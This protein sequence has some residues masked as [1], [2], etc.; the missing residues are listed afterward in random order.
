MRTE[1]GSVGDL[2]REGLPWT[3][4]DFVLVLDLY[5]RRGRNV[6]R[7]DDELKELA[8]LLRR[9]PGSITRRLGNFAGTESAGTRGL[10]AVT[11][12]GLQVWREFQVRP[13]LLHAEAGGARDRL[14]GPRSDRNSPPGP[15]VPV[16]ARGIRDGLADALRAELVGPVEPTEVLKERPSTRYACGILWPEGTVIEADQNEAQPPGDDEED[17]SGFEESVPLVQ[18]LNPSSI[19]LSV[20]LAPGTRVLSVDAQWGEY[21]REVG[22]RDSEEGEEEHESRALWRRAPIAPGP[23]RIPVDKHGSDRKPVSADGR[24]FVEWLVRPLGP[25]IA[26]SVFL[27]N[28]R[29]RP[30]GWLEREQR[31]IFQPVLSVFEEGGAPVIVGRHP[32]LPASGSGEADEVAARLLFRDELE[33]A[34]GHG[35]AAGWEREV[36]HATRAW[37]DTLPSIELPALVPEENVPGL[38]VDMGKLSDE[39]G[40]DGFERLLHPLTDAYANWIDDLQRRIPALPEH[41]REQGESHVAECRESLRRMRDGIE[42]IKTDATSRRAFRLMNMTMLLQR[43]R[44][45]WA[46]EFRRTGIRER[47]TPDLGARWRPFQL[48][49]ILQC[50]RGCVQTEHEDR[51]IA[52]LL[53]FPTGGGKT[54]AYLGLAAFV[55]FSRRLAHR[56]SAHQGAGVCVLMRYTLRLLTVQQF[57]RAATLAC[58]MEVVRARETDLGSEPF[59]VGIWVGGGTTPNTFEESDKALTRLIRGEGGEGSSLMDEG[60]P[61]QLVSC[62]WCGEQMTPRHYR[63]LGVRRRTL[64]GCPRE[65]CEFSFQS[66]PDGI[67]V[68]VVDEEIYRCLPTLIIGTVDKFARLP[69]KGEAQTLFGRVSRHCPRHGYLSPADD[70]PEARH[71]ARAN[72]SAV[73]VSSTDP[74]PPP[75]LIIQD[76]LHLISGP[77]G[78]MVGLYE[79]GID[80]LAARED[81]GSRVPPKVVASTATVRRA[82][83]QV[84]GLFKRSV[85]VFPPPGLE[86]V[87]SFF[88]RRAA[89]G[90]VPGRMYVGVF[91][92]GKSVK[93]AQVRVVALLLAAA[94]QAFEQDPASADPYMTLVGYFNSLRELGGA[95]NLVRDDIRERLRVLAGRGWPQRR[96][97]EPEELTSRRSSR[98]IPRLLDRLAVPH[99]EREGGKQP[100]DVLLS[101]NMISVG[102]DI[103]RLGL[104]VVVGQPKATAEYIQATSRVGRRAPG[105]IVTIYN[106]SRPRDLSHYERFRSYHSTLYRHVEAT[107][108]TPF[109]SRAR[110]RGLHAIYV[111]MCRAADFDLTP[112]QQ[113]VAYSRDRAVAAD[114]LD[115]LSDRAG[116]V[117]GP[118][119]AEAVRKE[120]VA[121]QDVWEQ[122]T[123][124][125]PLRYSWE[126]VE[127]LPPPGVAILLRLA[128]T[129]RSGV[130]ATPGS[131]REIESQAGI[132]LQEDLP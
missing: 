109:S 27:V 108:V 111:G 55:A 30:S 79:A 75:E 28:R 50:L 91:A 42:L 44:S 20:I 45:D 12:L 26:L 49:F 107:S 48:A 105:L 132:Y 113:A 92:P 97:W 25:A 89:L 90:E 84:W 95:V 1:G 52:D 6:P 112:E 64:M 124:G 13:D 116:A 62:P 94:Q 103:L 51:A 82:P 10:K 102:V 126:S 119:V 68:V 47:E 16:G 57:Q 63:A 80:W 93:T 78:S 21:V 36:D 9:S 72:L 106:W 53:W 5:V 71:G 114:A 117:G 2:G 88:A 77:L 131:L 74:L 86:H 99:A 70:H 29:S 61:V 54:E 58:A 100:V 67:P 38:E 128:G 33:F 85:K 32:D 76:E 35:C 98:Q 7:N 23:V 18:T 40:P 121:R 3:R 14:T 31:A 17:S 66:R 81:S 43:S 73:T 101:T 39:H 118:E 8:V 34:V 69:W 19:G 60:S 41:L 110:D 125:G 127:R 4:D 123:V 37:T 120:L 87:D 96:A 104:M 129:D 83:D 59:G 56:D 115:A 22:A 122:L 11:G 130:W 65:A 24:V 46:L 15:G